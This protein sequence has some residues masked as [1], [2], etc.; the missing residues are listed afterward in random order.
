MT[1][2]FAVDLL[3]PG[4]VA[5]TW[6]DWFVGTQGRR[7]LLFA[8]GGCVVVLI[9]AAVPYIVSQW[10]LS[11]DQGSLPQLRADLARRDGE[12]RLL[13]AD[14]QAL[15]VEAKR[16][17]RWAE[18]MTALSQQIPPTLKL[19]K[20]EALRGGPPPAAGPGQPAPSPTLPPA[21]EG[22]LRVEAIT[23]L[24]PGSPNMLEIAQFMA[25]LLKDP[26]VSKRFQ[27][28][29]WEIK[30]GTPA[31][32]GGQAQG[33]GEKMLQIVIVLSEIGR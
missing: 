2:R 4:R 31:S 22:E 15:S 18:V 10:R 14:L 20:V 5:R 13:R 26:A 27:L 11:R 30:P 25:G 16:Q 29:N 1:G 21:G 33:E 12:L 17:V 8:L 9:I 28:K 6:Q 3:H 32:G 7:R 24:K 23:P 19:T